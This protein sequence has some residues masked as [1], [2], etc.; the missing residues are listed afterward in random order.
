MNPG[1]IAGANLVGLIF[2]SIGRYVSANLIRRSCKIYSTPKNGHTFTIFAASP[3]HL[4][5]GK[6]LLH[7]A[8]AATLWFGLG[9][10]DF[11]WGI[12]LAAMVGGAVV[13]HYVWEQFLYDPLLYL[14][15]MSVAND[16]PLMLKAVD[17][18]NSTFLKFLEIY[19]EHK[20]DSM[21]RFRFETDTEAVENLWGDLLEINEHEATVYLRTPPIH[22]NGELERT[23]S[24]ERNQINDWM[25]EFKDGT[26]RG[27]YS[28]RALFKIY[29][30]E[31]GWLHPKLLAHLDRF[32]EVDW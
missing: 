25:V 17:N 27:G 9:F 15:A 16:D 20:S 29:E 24:I 7:I 19:P 8:T 32:K 1:W 13:V 26:L 22:H 5:M 3:E 6:T 21:V 2:V 11:H 12:R 28:N 4:R 30:R 18:A 14:G 23:M 10:L 31:E